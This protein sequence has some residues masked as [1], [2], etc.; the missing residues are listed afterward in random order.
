MKRMITKIETLL[1][2]ENEWKWIQ[3]HVF[4]MSMTCIFMNISSTWYVHTFELLIFTIVDTLDTT[5]DTTD[6]MKIVSV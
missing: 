4:Y 3:K 6:D 1:Q 5:F 2:K